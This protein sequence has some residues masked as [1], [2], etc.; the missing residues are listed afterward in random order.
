MSFRIEKIKADQDLL[1]YSGAAELPSPGAE[2]ASND[3]HNDPMPKL[4]CKN[5]GHLG[6]PVSL[7]MEYERQIRA[8]EETLAI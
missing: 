1:K 5:S 8:D 2:L 6:S 3:K 7:I 4:T